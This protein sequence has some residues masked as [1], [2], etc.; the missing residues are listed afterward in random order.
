MPRVT[1][2]SNSFTM[3]E[4]SPLMLG[5][6]D[7]DVYREGVLDMQ[8]MFADSRGPA[9]SRKGSRYIQTIDAD[10]GRIFSLPVN[11]NFFYTAI[12]TDL[13][14]TV[15]SASG[16]VPIT[17]HNF[18]P[19]FNNGE[20][21]WTVT[22]D[23]A[24]EVGFPPSQCTLDINDSPNQLAQI[25]QQVTGLDIDT[26]YA[27][28]WDLR[29]VET[30]QILV[31]TTEGSGDL[32]TAP[33]ASTTIAGSTFNTGA[34]TSVWVSALVSSDLVQVEQQIVLQYLGIADE[35]ATPVTYDTTCKE[36]E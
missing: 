14:L 29:G 3:G 20:E 15:S 35:I 23:G 26:D 21:F 33:S 19:N 6:S 13:L 8:N 9:I 27:V 36:S 4:L 7:L 22:E 2:I 34:N 5:R 30:G 1:P 28:L 31:G 16:R 25:S 12:F 32:F 10:A 11:E 24:G 17:T 18:N